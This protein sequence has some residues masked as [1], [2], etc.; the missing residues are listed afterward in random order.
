MNT[1]DTTDIAR[2][3]EG[4]M[5]DREK[6]AFEQALAVDPSLRGKLEEYYDIRASLHMKLEKDSGRKDLEATLSELRP[7]YF[8]GETKVIPFRR[9]LR[10][11]L[12]GAAAAILILLIWMPWK[13]DL[14]KKYADTKMPGVAERGAGIDSLKVVSEKAFNSH[15]F[16]KAAKS[17]SV[18]HSAEPDNAMFSFYY[19]VSLMKVDSLQKAR[20]LLTDLSSGRSV[21]K[22]ES[23]FYMGMTY[24]KAKDKDAAR[25]WLEKIPFGAANYEKAQKVLKDL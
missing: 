3:A 22:N 16:T 5:E 17:L 18:I 20:Q 1:Y 25:A 11:V 8:S 7:A 15:D 9:T 24:L 2:Y 10:R 23:L 21:Y 19:A 12:P 4:A 6:A 13:T 14:Y